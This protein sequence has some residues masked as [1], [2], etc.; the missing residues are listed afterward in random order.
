MDG[1]PGLQSIQDVSRGLFGQAIRID[2]VISGSQYTQSAISVNPLFK[3][4]VLLVAGTRQDTTTIFGFQE[5]IKEI[6]FA[7]FGGILLNLGGFPIL[8]LAESRNIHDFGRFFDDLQ[9]F[10][11]G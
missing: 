10:G 5:D 7:N 9:P 6:S 2:V 4:C 8:R 11:F 3:R 1:L